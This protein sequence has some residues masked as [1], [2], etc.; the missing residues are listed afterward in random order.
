MC[1]QEA[2]KAPQ[3]E[4]G[5]PV[6]PTRTRL[7]A[8]LAP[9]ALLLACLAP[10]S[11]SASFGLL[12]GEAGFKVTINA[13]AGGEP[14]T[15][16]GSHPDSLVTE[17]NLNKSGQFSD[18]DLKSLTY[19]LPPGLIEN[20]TAVPR[21]GSAQFVTARTSP[22]EESASGESCSGLAQ[23][24]IVTLKSSHGGGAER[25]FGLFNLAPSPGSPSRFGFSP[26][27][28]PITI[29]P[30]VREAG[31]EYGLTL[32]LE[33]FSQLLNV[34]SLR[35]EVWGSPFAPEHDGQ[36]G[37][38]LNEINPASP[39]GT[40][41]V[42]ELNPP[43][44]AQAYLTLP[45][46]CEVPL[47]FRVSL[48]SWQAPGEAV[49]RSQ[50]G[51]SPLTGCDKLTF[52]PVPRGRLST[53]RASSPTGYDFTLDGTS[54]PLLNPTARASSQAKKAV[55]KLPEGMSVNPSVGSGL[56]TCSEA[57]FAAETLDSAP[58]AGCPNESKVGELTIE[59]PLVEGQIEG[60]MFFATP[61][62]NRFGTLIALYMVAKDPDR[63]IL[64]KVAGRV[65]SDPATGQ[66]TT[67]FDDLPQLPYSHFNVHFRE[68]QRSPLA[69]PSAC[70]TYATEVDTS[71]WLDPTIVVHA[72]SPFTLS[73]G[74][75]GGACQQG[76]LAPFAPGASGG[77]ANGNAS[78]YTPFDL[79]L[80]RSDG[81]QEITSYSAVLPPG[82]L[83]KIAGIPFCPEASI[84]AAKHQS[85]A[86]SE[87]APA[88][89]QASLIGHTYTGY[90]VGKSLAYAPGTLYLAGP[91]HGQP[92]SVVAI[93]SAK[94]GPFDL[95][96]VVIRS[97]IR[98]D[99]RTAQVAIDSAGS[100]PIPHILKGFPLRLR[101]IGIA[102]DRP[103]FMVNPTNCDP[104]R[105]TSTLTGSGLAFGDPSD[106]QS[107]TSSAP[108]QVSNCSALDFSPKLAISLSGGHKR[109]VYPAL[110]ATV[111]TQAGDANIGSA[112][113]TLPPR[114]FLASEHLESVCTP[115]QFAA[116]ACPPDSVYGT[117]SATTPLLETPLSGPVYLRANNGER[118]LPDLVADLSGRGVEIEVLGK[119]DSYKGG[120]R[121]RFDE[122]PD[123]PVTSFTMAL[124]GKEHGLIVNAT[125]TCLHPQTATAKFV[126]QENTPG[127]RL[128][129]L[130]VKCKSKS[131]KAN[132]RRAGT[133]SSRTPSKA[134]ERT[135]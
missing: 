37:N 23:I 33:N 88:C 123:A 12:P 92:L 130:T 96:T 11:A 73:A 16:A 35:F 40:C 103:G 114:L 26:Y 109:R 125:D 110:R 100:D 134:P 62:E 127:K 129:P 57:Q 5:P 133:R 18:G 94:V 115:R 102:I 91:Y 4:R 44:P 64:V 17:L 58:G 1:E 32:E 69:T 55:V 29:A 50:T 25:S 38:C 75:G 42:A 93:D 21:C 89:P 63:G 98:V 9:L 66:L 99:P 3:E 117:A 22:Y 101:D 122:L 82:E 76:P 119:I 45:S 124:K 65:D 34:S 74:P 41:A 36:R 132:K 80:T 59:S 77:V 87:I 79:H 7:A 106:D 128:V 67:T 90:G 78:S 118:P 126:G 112:I 116:H 60:S 97:A 107:S 104:F 68:G 15:L 105:L 121:T 81:E 111:T 83:G 54:A 120:L 135:R 24:G 52:N 49:G 47:V 13:D 61:N 19:D 10:A 85:G 113:V 131:K 70:G 84:E 53:E 56:G 28:E 27:G 31:R 6:S 95:G 2:E 108:F 51:A 14:T 71:P 30:R 43:H 8:A 72:S 39:H 48:T 20:P 86:E 46:S